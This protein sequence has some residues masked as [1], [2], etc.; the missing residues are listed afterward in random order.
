MHK[1]PLPI[2]FM[3]RIATLINE[4]GFSVK[5]LL[6]MPEMQRLSEDG[7]PPFY[8][9]S[10][11]QFLKSLV[12]LTDDPAMALR[13]GKQL[14]LASYGTFGFA[15]MSCT[16]LKQV[17]S[18]LH[19]YYQITTG[20]GPNIELLEYKKGMALR[21]GFER[22]DPHLN[23]LLTEVILTQIVYLGEVLIDS[24][25]DDGEVHFNYPEPAHVNVYRETFSAPIKFNQPYNQ[26]LIPEKW[27]NSP[28]KT[29]N[30]AGHVVF[31]QQCE[32]ILRS[33]N[34]TENFSSTVRRVLIRSAGGFPELDE[35][36]SRL[37]ISGR[38]LRRRLE[39][40][41]TSFREIVDEVKNVLACKYLETTELTVEEIAHLLGYSEAVSFRRAF[42]RLN[43]KTPNEYRQDKAQSN[44]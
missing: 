26:I 27:L 35:V 34:K 5:Q 30:P 18:L 1:R 22:G 12:D 19:R 6:S 29:A 9:D 17:T 4:Q 37:N 13:L 42:I 25:I 20:P 7:R 24:I 14:E 39:N 44:K 8:T 10:V 40:E 33:I 11:P 31:Q 23:Q 28:I 41:S 15:L 32:E 3:Q 16:N 43:E 21:I 38:T 2:G 36:A